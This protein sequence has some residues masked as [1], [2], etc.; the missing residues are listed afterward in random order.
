M[1]DEKAGIAIVGN[2]NVGKSALFSRMSGTR[3]ESLNIAGN[4]TSITAGHVKNT[5]REIFDTPGTIL[6]IFDQ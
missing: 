6:N 1:I 4:T 5:E 3:T 2:M